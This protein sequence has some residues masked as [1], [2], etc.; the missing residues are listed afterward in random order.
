MDCSHRPTHSCLSIQ[1]FKLDAH[2]HKEIHWMTVAIHS[3]ANLPCTI[4][5]ME[6]SSIG[7]VYSIFFFNW[8]Q[9]IKLYW[10][11]RWTKTKVEERRW[12]TVFFFL[13]LTQKIKLYWRRKR[14][15][16]GGGEG[17]TR[18]RV[19]SILLASLRI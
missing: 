19:Y 2:L 6:L 15:G 8:T 11:K 7:M 5:T 14:R 10:R 9:K 1:I 3:S 13:N 17:R 12:F 18:V 4:L 16:V